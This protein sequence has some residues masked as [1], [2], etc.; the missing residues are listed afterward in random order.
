MEVCD[1]VEV[2]EFLLV[3]DDSV[4]TTSGDQVKT[5]NRM[6]LRDTSCI[7]P[8]HIYGRGIVMQLGNIPPPF[9]KMLSYRAVDSCLSLSTMSPEK[10]FDALRNDE[11][12]TGIIRITTTKPVFVRIEVNGETL[13]FRVFRIKARLVFIGFREY[14]VRAEFAQTVVDVERHW[15]NIHVPMFTVDSLFELSPIQ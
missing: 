13:R 14:P 10:L 7:V 4:L 12:M 3:E 1:R 15:G 2:D 9:L 11:R 6:L 5:P 8:S